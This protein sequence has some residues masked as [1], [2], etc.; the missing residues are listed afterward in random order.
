MTVQLVLL[1]YDFNN[2]RVGYKSAYGGV[3]K[4]YMPIQPMQA[5]YILT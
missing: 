2:S 3:H 1:A 5:I 4:G